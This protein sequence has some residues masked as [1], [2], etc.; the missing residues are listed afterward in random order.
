MGVI[1]MTELLAE[2]LARRVEVWMAPPCAIEDPAAASGSLEA[3]VAPLPREG[4]ASPLS[5]QQCKKVLG[6]S[7][8]LC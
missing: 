6:M 5:P 8:P 3:S 2:A 1:C 7:K 4:Q